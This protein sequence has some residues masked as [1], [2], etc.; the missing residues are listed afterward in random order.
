MYDN[1]I[2]KTLIAFS[3]LVIFLSYFFYINWQG[4]NKEP[5]FIIQNISD[6]SVNIKASWR[7]SHI[8]IS[9]LKKGSSFTFYL[10]EEASM[11]LII[12]YGSGKVEEKTIG[13]FTSGSSYTIT[14][15]KNLTEITGA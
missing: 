3:I 13:Y 9:N 12:E 6:S 5:E 4:I 14:V 15:G 1:M 7:D 2:K 8:S 10:R 11:K